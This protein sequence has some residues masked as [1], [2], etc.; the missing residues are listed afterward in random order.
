MCLSF[1]Q[2]LQGIVELGEGQKKSWAQLTLERSQINLSDICEN[3]L[4]LLGLEE[5][6]CAS[7]TLGLSE[8]LH[9]LLPGLT[10]QV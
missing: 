8:T 5:L 2:Q 3:R 9:W 4:Q 1:K 7:S 6:H 10:C